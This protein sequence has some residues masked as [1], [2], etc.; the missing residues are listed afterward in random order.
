MITKRRATL[1]DRRPGRVPEQG[2]GAATEGGRKE[3]NRGRDLRPDARPF[4]RRSPPVGGALA[5]R[6]DERRPGDLRRPVL[7]AQPGRVSLATPTRRRFA[8]IRCKRTLGRNWPLDLGI[9]SS[10]KSLS[11]S[12][13]RPRAARKRD[14]W[15]NELAGAR[16]KFEKM[17]DG[18]HELGVKYSKDTN[19]L[20]PAAL[21]KEVH[22]FFYKG[23]ID[24][25]QTVI[26][27]GGWTIG[28]NIG[29]WQRAYRPGPRHRLPVSIWRDRARP[30]HDD[31]R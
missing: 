19:H 11:R 16:Q 27:G 25:K 6:R 7:H 8:S 23:D 13:G 24:P 28:V 22:D 31:R 15:V 12:I 20:H 30:G 10:E 17:L 21:C 2:L 26:G 1:A 4:P 9:V 5:R 3:R 18:Q 14:A 29:R